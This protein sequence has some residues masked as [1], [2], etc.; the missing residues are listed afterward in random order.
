MTRHP[1]VPTRAVLIVKEL[2]AV[3]H[4]A[5]IAGLHAVLFRL[6]TLNAIPVP[7]LLCDSVY[8]CAM[9]C[10]TLMIPG[11][12]GQ[13]LNCCGNSYRTPAC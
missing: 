5:M 7:V 6:Y 11:N 13:M 1:A 3:I 10:C 12:P 8:N 9:I 4:A 2:M